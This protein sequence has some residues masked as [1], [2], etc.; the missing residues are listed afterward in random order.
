MEIN[1][2]TAV[3]GAQTAPARAPPGGSGRGSS[4]RPGRY[5]NCSSGPAPQGL[6]QTPCPDATRSKCRIRKT[7]PAPPRRP[8]HTPR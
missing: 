2:T 5:T 4:P 7:T 8:K 6:A 3:G 1:Q